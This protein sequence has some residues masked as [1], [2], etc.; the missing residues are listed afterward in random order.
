MTDINS[1]IKLANGTGINRLGLGTWRLTGAEV[2]T[3][4]LAAAEAGY[5]RFDTAS[6]YENESEL[7]EALA[8]TGLAR[9]EY[10]VTS[11]N[12][13]SEQGA[14]ATGEACRRSLERLRLDYLD[15]YLLHWP[16]RTRSLECWG[17][18]ERL[19][20]DGL[21]KAVGVS[22][23]RENHLAEL[24]KIA[25][26]RPMVNQIELHPY[27]TQERISACCA[28]QG[29]VVE[30]YS[31]LCRGQFK[32][33][34]FFQKMARKHGR[35]PAQ[36]V[37]RW[38]FQSG[39]AFIPKASSPEHVC[40]NAAIFDFVLT[41]EDMEGIGRQNQNRSVLKPPFEFDAEGWIV[42]GGGK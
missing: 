3:A 13:N 33:N 32:K 9:G 26:V 31:P 4:V 42:E 22:N 39:R 12:W 6:A 11:K 35:T 37:L 36:I 20:E 15:L 1:V 8:A 38:H 19:L 29:L 41:P 25:K 7:G 21:V 34:Q 27:L 17:D 5:R 10:F 30:A 24:L 23:F 14:G 18:M 16:V 2:R 28:A 40:E